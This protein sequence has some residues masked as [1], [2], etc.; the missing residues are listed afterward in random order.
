M[1]DRSG[2][3]ASL[4]RAAIGVAAI[5]GVVM[6]GGGVLAILFGT[7]GGNIETS[8]TSTPIA[9]QTSKT[10]ARAPA[11]A[12][13]VAPEAATGVFSKNAV[14]AHDY[15][16]V[17]AHPAAA[18]IGAAVLADGGTAADA[19]IAAQMVLNLV[20]PQSSGIGGGGFLLYWDAEKDDLYSY[21]GRET[22]PEN[23]SDDYL[24][25]SDGSFKSFTE[26]LTGGAS[27]GVP[28]LVRMLETVHRDHGALPWADL[29]QPAI[30]L[31]EE[32]F[33]VSPRM[34][35]L[36]GETAL[37]DQ[38]EPAASY[39]FDK[40]TGEPLAV[41]T[42]LRNPELAAT[43]RA[44]AEGGAD[45]FYQGPIAEAMV[46][47]VRG[48]SRNPGALSLADLASY[49][50]KRRDNL[51]L[52][53]RIYRVCGMAPPSSGGSTVLQILG[54]LEYAPEDIRRQSPGSAD[55][56]QIFSEA[57]RLA[58]A[59]RNQFLADTDFVDVPL[60][61]MLA[62]PYLT[63]RAATMDLGDDRKVDR[64]PGDPVGD[65]AML[66]LFAPDTSPELPST[67]HLVAVDRNGS[68]ATMTSSIENGFGSRVM[69][70]G[71]LLNNQLTDFAWRT[72]RD[73]RPVAN[74]Y[75]PG[76][77]PRSS[78]AP[79]LVFG[80]GGEPRLALGSPGGSRIIG[81]VAKTLVGV[82]DWELS[83]QEAMELPHFLNRNGA[84]ELEEN[85]ILDSASQVLES[86]GYEVS[87][88]SMAS[89]LHGIEFSGGVLVGGADP[90]REG[91]AVGERNL[92]RNL[93]Q[94]FET[95]LEDS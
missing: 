44:I 42:V 86:R 57:M 16:M 55:S 11:S 22:A 71:F 69:V 61:E 85:T 67:T 35:A 77:R 58:F 10:N 91:M 65:R 68:V 25:N 18:Q 14:Y 28:G 2:S 26:A 15:M 9:A 30:K 88:R 79:T 43:F 46:A 82:L 40:D 76:K 17:A 3:I 75:E 8:P 38:M 72:E 95:F 21:D 63:Q 23:G 12:E 51:C 41:G 50:A 7:P 87:R 49:T 59:D 48:A 24:R 29:F 93:D 39:F 33:P 20:E 34:H 62:V 47:A 19:V 80:P 56:I 53:Y 81:Y 78:M 27:V 74:R 84:L 54:L 6:L 1:T 83:I 4:I 64:E 31:A 94:V 32:G 37:L 52:H 90:R 60:A 66:D 73:G 36:I 92:N 13:S 5:G 45:A 89:G 70:G